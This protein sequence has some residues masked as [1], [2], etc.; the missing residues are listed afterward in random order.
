MSP[1]E[2]LI[3]PVNRP[4]TSP[5]SLRRAWGPGLG[6]LQH[7]HTQEDAGEE[8]E[9]PFSGASLL[10]GRC[11]CVVCGYVDMQICRYVDVDAERVLWG[12]QGFDKVILRWASSNLDRKFRFIF[13]SH[14]ILRL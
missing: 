3:T 7:C 2:T 5:N 13:Y 6:R 12:S 10:W 14:Q 11:G 4:T 1:T 8:P 9:G